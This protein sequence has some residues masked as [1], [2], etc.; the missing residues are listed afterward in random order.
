M[1]HRFT[2]GSF[3][4]Q[5]TRGSTCCANN[6]GV[7]RRCEARSELFT[8]RGHQGLSERFLQWKTRKLSRHLEVA[9][10][11]LVGPGCTASC[12]W[13]TATCAC[14]DS[15]GTSELVIGPT[16]RRG[17]HFG[18][19]GKQTGPPLKHL[20]GPAT[21]YHGQQSWEFLRRHGDTQSLSGAT[22]PKGRRFVIR[23]L[24]YRGDG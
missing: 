15:T 19:G 13:E 4:K 20:A 16:T 12:K 14:C 11:A 17:V 6:L 5:D 1:L 18:G 8:N 23:R 21:S 3:G 24:G 9:T 22:F 2:H 7:V 10:G